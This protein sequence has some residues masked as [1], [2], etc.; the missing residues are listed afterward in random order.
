MGTEKVHSGFKVCGQEKGAKLWFTHIDTCPWEVRDLPDVTV[1][2]AEVLRPL[3]LG[4][5]QQGHAE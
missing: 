1:A 2:P 4:P 5:D 3:R